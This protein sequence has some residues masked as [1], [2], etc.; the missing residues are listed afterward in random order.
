MTIRQI[1]L[2]QAFIEE[3]ENKIRNTWQEPFR[4]EMTN[5]CRHGPWLLLADKDL[6]IS[7]KEF[8]WFQDASV[9]EMTNVERL[10]HD[11]LD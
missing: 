2:A 7:F 8:P 6:F 1:R 9:P 11:Y 5:I 4:V 3:H 10:I